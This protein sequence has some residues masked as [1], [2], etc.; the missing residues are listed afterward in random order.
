M[1][2]L[3]ND[4]ENPPIVPDF[5]DIFPGN[6][7]LVH[8]IECANKFIAEIRALGH[9]SLGEVVRLGIARNLRSEMIADCVAIAFNIVE[10]PE[11]ATR[12]YTNSD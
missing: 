9:T 3:E 11:C 8:E 1:T 2:A 12:I 4:I 6:L 10:V 7:Q 5:R